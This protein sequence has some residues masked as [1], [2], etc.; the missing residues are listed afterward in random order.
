[1]IQQANVKKE[2]KAYNNKSPNTGTKNE[3]CRREYV[4]FVLALDQATCKFD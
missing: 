2:N 4:D 3:E 1:M